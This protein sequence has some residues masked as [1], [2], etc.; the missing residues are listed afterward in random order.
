MTRLLLAI[1]LLTGTA[2][3]QCVWKTVPNSRLR[4]Q[5]CAGS[6][7]DGVIGAYEKCMTVFNVK[8]L[9]C[10]DGADT[11]DTCLS[12]SQIEA[13]RIAHRPFDYPFALA[14]G[15]TAFPGWN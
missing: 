12:D 6:S 7:G 9:R 1:C 8:T 14:N 15:V 3:A 11:G 4:Y 5:D 13:D 2:Y 10:P